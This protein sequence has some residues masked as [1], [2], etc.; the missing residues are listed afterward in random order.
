[1]IGD[2]GSLREIAS[3]EI[4]GV[5]VMDNP[6]EIISVTKLD[7]ARRHLSTAI[8]LW[9]HD[10]DPVS[11]HTL[12]YAAYEVIYVLSRKANRTDT[13]IFDSDVIKD[14][15]RS[16]FNK[17]VKKAPNF[18]KHADKDTNNTLE[19]MPKF[20]EMFFLFRLLDLRQWA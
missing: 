8:R 7:A 9:F 3:F 11:I 19:F 17:L 14:E 16:D 6:P 20:S 18:F 4:L 13:L 12:G 15:F 5:S 1:V 2:G 10:G